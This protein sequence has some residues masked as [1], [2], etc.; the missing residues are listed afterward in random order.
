MSQNGTIY[1]ATNLINKKQ[2]VGQTTK[3]L[4]ERI[5]GHKYGSNSTSIL[6]KAIKKYGFRNFKWVS[7]S[8]PEEDLDWQETFLIKELNVLVPNGYNLDSGGNT[9]KHRHEITKQ[10]IRKKELGKNSYWFGK[11]R[12]EEDRKK[13]SE[14]L[15]WFKGENHS[16]FGKHHK[17]ESKKILSDLNKGENNKMAKLT[18]V[19]IIKIREL[20]NKKEKQHKIAKIFS[21]TQTT[22]SQIKLGKHWK[23]I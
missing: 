5:T 19:D 22:I 18:E 17:E 9:Q 8:C 21:V 7:F 6:H 2:Y 23:H 15:S 10:K 1:I 14:S 13:K 20:L 4:K 16:W 3:T 12:S 11:S